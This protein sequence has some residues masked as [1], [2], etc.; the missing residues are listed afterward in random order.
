MSNHDYGYRTSGPTG[1]AEDIYTSVLQ[2]L[3]AF[4]PAGSRVLDLGCGNGHFTQRLVDAG[5]V[6]TGTDTSP[7]G[8]AVAQSAHPGASFHCGMIDELMSRGEPSFDAVVSVEVIEH[9]PSVSEFCAGLASCIK[10][11]GIGIVTTPYHG[12]LKNLAIALLGKGDAHYNPLWE[13]GHI[14]FFSPKTLTEAMQAAQLNVLG[15]DY[16]GRIPVLAKSMVMSVQRAS[17]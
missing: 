15:V 8:I 12:Y 10:P 17:A 5:Y 3:S 11:G 6:A 14:K 1:T 4:L 2:K 7:S 16:V 13:G 9:C